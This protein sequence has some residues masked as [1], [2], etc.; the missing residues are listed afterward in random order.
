M[1]ENMKTFLTV[2]GVILAFETLKAIFGYGAALTVGVA[3]LSFLIGALWG[4]GK[5]ASDED[6]QA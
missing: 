2:A 5:S 1:S 3:V 4:A 6:T